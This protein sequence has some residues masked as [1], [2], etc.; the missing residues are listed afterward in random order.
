M[1]SWL[2]G[3]ILALIAVPFRLPAQTAAIAVDADH[4]GVDD[5]LEAALLERFRPVFMVSGGDCD[6]LPAEF[7]AA[8]PAAFAQHGAIPRA[9]ARNGTIYG[10]VFRRGTSGGSELIEAHFYHLWTRDCGARGHA[11]DAEHVSVLLAGASL[12]APALDWSAR[13]WYAAAHQE[14]LCDVSRFVSAG[15]IDATQRGATVWISAGKHAS[16][17]SAELCGGGCGKDRCES[18]VEL[19]NTPVVNLGEAGAP[20]N[21]AGWIASPRWP[22][23]Q[24]MR[25]DFPDAMLAEGA[26]APQAP[27]SRRSAQAVIGAGASASDATGSALDTA[28][29]HYDHGI[30][31]GAQK[32]GRSL[33]R[34][35]V[36]T[37]RFLGLSAKKSKDSDK[38]TEAASQP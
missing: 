11:L 19:A 5:V 32:T 21:G 28:G 33:K 8:L 1:R 35:L 30:D 38:A 23:A 37:G 24:K 3:V 22:L 20:M 10:Q 26:A 7:A 31:V 6:Q 27:A 14:T 29:K 34:A 4:D 13:T 18:M 12:S 17:F 25:S 15:E 9:I 16:Y 2:L 36:A